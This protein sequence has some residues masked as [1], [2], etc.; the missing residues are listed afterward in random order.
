MDWWTLLTI[1]ATHVQ[2][3]SS[4]LSGPGGNL[5]SLGAMPKWLSQTS[6]MGAKCVAISTETMMIW[7]YTMVYRDLGIPYLET[8]PVDPSWLLPNKWKSLL[9]H[10]LCPTDNLRYLRYTSVAFRGL[11]R[12]CL[13][14]A[15]HAFYF[16]V[17]KSG[18]LHFQAPPY[19]DMNCITVYTY[20]YIYTYIHI[21]IYIYV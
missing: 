19:H 20:I 15:D 16:D 7:I 6:G 13:L 10:K 9:P 4:S 12:T 1:G 2:E 18:A 21:Y 17:S 5:S 14:A 8:S 11:N 3:S